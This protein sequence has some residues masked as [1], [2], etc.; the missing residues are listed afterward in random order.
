MHVIEELCAPAPLPQ[1]K[2]PTNPLNTK[3]SG[4]HVNNY[5]RLTNLN[6]CLTI[7]ILGR[8]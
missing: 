4:Q 2:D 1:G 8:I 7:G 5:E 6:V 3:V